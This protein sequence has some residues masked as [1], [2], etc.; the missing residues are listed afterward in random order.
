MAGLGSTLSRFRDI[1]SGLYNALLGQ[2]LSW[3]R[4]NAMNAYD[5]SNDLF[6]AFLHQEKGVWTQ[7]GPGLPEAA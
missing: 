2:L 1:G 6:E 3:A 4:L 7:V 5:Q